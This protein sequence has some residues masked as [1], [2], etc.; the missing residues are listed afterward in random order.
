M[1]AFKHLNTSAITTNII[2]SINKVR[3]LD[4]NAYLNISD[5]FKLTISSLKENMDYK[6][7]IS[8]NSSESFSKEPHEVIYSCYRIIE[9]DHDNN[10]MVN[11][12]FSMII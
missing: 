9:K 5:M 1:D 8:K 7:W 2:M 12:V 11:I 3:V 10:M 4:G 6:T